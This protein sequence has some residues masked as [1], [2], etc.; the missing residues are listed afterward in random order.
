MFSCSNSYR[1]SG[2]MRLYTTKSYS[3]KLKLSNKEYSIY[4]L[5]KEEAENLKVSFLE[6]SFLSVSHT[7][8][9]LTVIAETG[10]KCTISP[11]SEN[12]GWKAI[13]I[14]GIIP[15]DATGVLNAVIHPLSQ[16]KDLSLLTFS[17]FHTDYFFCKKDKVD[18]ACLLLKKAGF[19]VTKE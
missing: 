14:E 6:K 8:D 10:Y 1:I 11:I 17:T 19:D 12:S 18:S 3:Y 5:P 4:K 16:D 2:F 9:E 15:F 13:Y 7:K